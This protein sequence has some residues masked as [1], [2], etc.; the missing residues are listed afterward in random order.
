MYALANMADC[1]ITLSPIGLPSQVPMRIYK[2]DAKNIKYYEINEDG[3]H[4]SMEYSSKKDPKDDE[5]NI[6]MEWKKPMVPKLN[7]TNNGSVNRQIRVLDYSRGTTTKDNI[8]PSR[9]NDNKLL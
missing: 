2:L 9:N 7:T 5:N 3:T 6:I 4:F 8:K 1:F